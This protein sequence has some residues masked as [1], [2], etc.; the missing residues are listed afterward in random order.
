[1]CVCACVIIY[2]SICFSQLF[3]Y[4]ISMRVCKISGMESHALKRKRLCLDSLLPA[5]ML[6][7]H[8]FILLV[9]LAPASLHKAVIK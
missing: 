2:E 4:T 9:P 7:A 5:E 6:R 3:N 1:M 8:V